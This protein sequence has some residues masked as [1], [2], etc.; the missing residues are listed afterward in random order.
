MGSPFPLQHVSGR[1]RVPLCVA[2]AAWMLLGTAASGQDMSDRQGT[3]Q[4]TGDFR[5]AR[6]Y[7][8]P[9]QA[10]CL[11]GT[12]GIPSLFVERIQ[13][14]PSAGAV[15]VVVSVTLD[16]RV[17]VGDWGSARLRVI[18]ERGV[19]PA[20]PGPF[21]L[22][23]GSPSRPT[24][25]TIVWAVLDLPAAEQGYGFALQIRPHDGTGDGRVS[26]SGQKLRP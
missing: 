20:S 6:T 16:Y 4:P 10:A 22:S 5:L 18:S 12:C 14:P 17:S 15:D 11:S 26:I 1:M 24:T 2:L 7:D 25:S 13:T 3:V 19:F 8:V 21:P 9:W 23:G